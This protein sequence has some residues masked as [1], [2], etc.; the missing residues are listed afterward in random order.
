MFTRLATYALAVI[1][2]LPETV[3]GIA[4]QSGS[5]GDA[6][7]MLDR[8][9]IALKANEADA[10]RAF[11]DK[12]NEKYHD[13]DLYVF[14]FNV[15]DGEF[16][17]HANPALIGTDA[18]ATRVGNDPVGQRI[19]DTIKNAAEETISTVEYAAPKPGTTQPPVPKESFVT[20]INGLG[21]GVG[22]Y[23]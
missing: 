22:Y 23:K 17:A 21:C 19:F 1:V 20:P 15:T 14:C 10:L 6:R 11:N 9:V 16:R 8:A 3:L 18:R 12:S 5:A 13:R 2:L 4:Q 7:A